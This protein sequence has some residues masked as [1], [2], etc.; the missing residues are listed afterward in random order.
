ML[1]ESSA[2]EKWKFPFLQTFVLGL[3]RAM[4]VPALGLDAAAV[5][6][7]VGLVVD[8]VED[9][10]EEDKPSQALIDVRDPDA[11]NVKDSYGDRDDDV[12]KLE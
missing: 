1:K 4:V 3:L 9:I 12:L 6:G 10:D 5:V 8:T 11:T 7:A 2:E